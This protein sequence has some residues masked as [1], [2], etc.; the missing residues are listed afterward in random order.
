MSTPNGE[1]VADALRCIQ[2]AWRVA[3]LFEG[4]FTVTGA[5]RATGW[6]M[7][8]TTNAQK[9]AARA[10]TMRG[11]VAIGHEALTINPATAGWCAFW[12]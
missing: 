8:G 1:V 7:I 11:L 9:L 10:A 12:G 2:F 3:F 4:C 5:L 6:R